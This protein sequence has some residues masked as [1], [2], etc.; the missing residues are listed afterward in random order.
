MASARLL[1]TPPA[2]AGTTSAVSWFRL[3]IV[4]AA[5]ILA[6][7]PFLL[8]GS[9]FF[10]SDEAVEGLMARHVLGGEFPLY[11]W[12]QRYKGVPEVYLSAAAFRAWPGGAEDVITLKAVTLACFALYACLNFRLLEQCFSRRVAWIATVF[13]IAGPPTLVLWSLS[14]SPDIVMTLLAGTTLL[15]GFTAWRRNGSRTGLVMAAASLG[16]GLWIQQYI[17]YYA[18]ALAIAAVDWTPSGRARLRELGAAATLPAWLRF[19]IHLFTA[20]ALV[21]IAFG[22]AAF[23]GL[24]FSVSLPGAAI[25][26]SHPQKMWW[27]AA[28]LLSIAAA[29]LSAGLLMQDRRWKMWLAPALG[30]LAGFSPAIAGRLFAEG[31]GAPMGRMDFTG[32]QSAVAPFGAT[33]LPMVFGFKGPGAERLAVP[34]WSALVVIAAVVAGYAGLR[35]AHQAGEAGA[36]RVDWGPY[37][38][39]FH[40]YLIVAPVMFLASGSF[41]DAQS[42]RYLMPLH[43]AL[44]V[45]Y[46]VGIEAVWRASRIS[47]LVLL[48]ALA[49]VFIVQQADWHRRLQPDRETQRIIE[50]LDD[51]G[52]RAAYADYWLSYKLTFLTGER[53][54]VSPVNGVD[55]YPRYTAFVRAQPVAP[56]IERLPGGATA[57]SCGATIKAGR[58]GVI[59]T[60]G[61]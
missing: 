14:G 8:Q 30:F 5:V 34:A 42:Y 13:V 51:A 24:G 39:V 38:G 7:L 58:R 22:V 11:L 55:R 60:S 61:K 54:I 43:A 59:V 56:A 37:P 52:V 10:D 12:G 4:A 6:R 26:V 46:A 44:P 18:A 3:A 49:G 27:I 29:G 53:I 36:D 28:M 23:F 19:S 32:L 35:R 33:T 2:V 17:L 9:R 41:I 25:T 45:V 50:C 16:F 57:T 31:Y 40:A 1:K 21:Y 15:L 47:G 48:A 20:V